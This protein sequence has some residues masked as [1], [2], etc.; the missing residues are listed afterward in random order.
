MND[1]EIKD[2]T[3]EFEKALKAQGEFKY[4]LRLFVSGMTPRSIRAIEN[5]KRICEERLKSR[6]EL[7]VVDIYQRPDLI[8]GEQLV[9]AP[10]LIKKLPEPLRKMI[11]DLSDTEKV[12]VA[13]D[14]KPRSAEVKEQPNSAGKEE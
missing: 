5:I 4:V 8:K 1:F 9:T 2:S 12:L 6:Y 13:L 10:T 7:E 14:L 3:E 11:G